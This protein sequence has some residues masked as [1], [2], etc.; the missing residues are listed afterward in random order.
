M[1]PSGAIDKFRGDTSLPGPPHR[2]RRLVTTPTPKVR[3]CPTFQVKPNR[4]IGFAP[5]HTTQRRCVNRR[6]RASGSRRPRRSSPH[7]R[8]RSR[9][10][11]T[12]GR[13]RD[14]PPRRWTGAS[15]CRH[16]PA[17][18]YRAPRTRPSGGSA[19]TCRRRRGTGTRSVAQQLFYPPAAW[20]VCSATPATGAE[21]PFPGAGDGP[22]GIMVCEPGPGGTVTAGPVLTTPPAASS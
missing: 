12:N 17:G 11:R 6:R 22:F 18:R 2:P 3:V 20:R 10:G 5:C 15:P 19:Q 13:R 7:R 14:R 21:S 16:G 8:S 9:G 1:S 4:Q